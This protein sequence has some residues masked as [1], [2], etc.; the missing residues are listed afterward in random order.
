[1]TNARKLRK[2]GEGTV[3]PARGHN[4]SRLEMARLWRWGLLACATIALVACQQPTY[5]PVDVAQNDVCFR[6]KA[7]IIEKQYAAE[8]A[9]KDRFVRKFDDLVCMADY[10]QN[11]MRKEN[12]GAFY[13]VDYPTK[14]WLPAEQA[15]YVKSEQ[16]KTPQNGGIL[17]FKD[18]GQ[19]EKLAAQYQAK[20]LAFGDIVK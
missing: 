1:M 19:A 5:K 9:T 17:A 18:K 15:A 6:C 7:P 14:T 3:R 10:V 16:F 2:I 12:I 8:F 4:P 20:L 13:V 11:K